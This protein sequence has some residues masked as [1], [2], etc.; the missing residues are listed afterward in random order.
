[1]ELKLKLKMNAALETVFDWKIAQ[2]GK[3]KGKKVA[4][5]PMNDAARK[6][7]ICCD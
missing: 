7:I 5:E 6:K 2:N 3:N 1:M 4:Y